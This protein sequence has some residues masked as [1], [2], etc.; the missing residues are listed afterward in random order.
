MPVRQLSQ[1]SVAA[2]ARSSNATAISTVL[3]EVTAGES[4]SGAV[5]SSTT[6]SVSE[7]DMDTRSRSWLVRQPQ[8]GALIGI[9]LIRRRNPHRSVRIYEAS[10][11]GI[12]TYAN[13]GGFRA[14]SKSRESG[15]RDLWTRLV[16]Y[17]R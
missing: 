2:R 9:G 1:P 13:A 12:I 17:R 6:I 4:S 3:L 8:G 14:S 5:G 15:D 11:A 16:P 10:L 7:L